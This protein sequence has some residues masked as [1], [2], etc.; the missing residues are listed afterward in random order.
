MPPSDSDWGTR[1]TDV[2]S[3]SKSESRGCSCGVPLAEWESKITS[4]EPETESKDL[5]KGVVRPRTGSPRAI[6][7]SSWRIF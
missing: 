7:R 1:P 2:G 4:E 6:L 3:E 5:T